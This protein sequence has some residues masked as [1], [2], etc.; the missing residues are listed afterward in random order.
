MREIGAIL[1]AGSSVA[2][3]WSF[4]GASAS[5]SSGPDANNLEAFALSALSQDPAVAP[6]LKVWTSG[7]RRQ[8]LA[9]HLLDGAVL[10]ASIW[11]FVVSQF[12]SVLDSERADR[13][14]KA[15]DASKQL[16]Q[17]LFNISEVVQSDASMDEVLEIIHKDV[18]QLMYA[19]NF[20]VLT[21]D[22]D[23]DLVQLRY[24]VDEMDEA[25]KVA[26]RVPY[27]ATQ[28]TQSL[29]VRMMI[30]GKPLLGPSDDLCVSLG[31]STHPA[32]GSPS[33]AWLG[34]PMMS[35][36]VVRGAIVVQSY[37]EEAEYSEESLRILEFVAQHLQMALDQRREIDAL[38][39]RVYERTHQLRNANM[40][41][42]NEISERQR[43]EALQRTLFRI[44]ELSTAPISG[45]R[46]FSE[47]HEIISK[48]VDCQNFFIALLDESHEYL[49]LAY[50]IDL[51]GAAPR[52][53][54]RL[55]SITD[56]V[57]SHGRP[58]LLDRPAIQKMI[59]EG[60]V[61][62]AGEIP[63]SWLGVPLRKENS[64]IGAM[65]VQSYNEHVVYDERDLELFVFAA[66]QVGGALSRRTAV[67]ELE[68]RVTRRTQELAR[69]NRAL[70]AEIAERIRVEDRL[71]HQAQHDVLTGL[72]N[73]RQLL[74]RL[75][76]DMRNARSD[77]TVPSFAV[78][79]LDM[80]Q[81]KLVNDS[82]GHAAGDEMLVDVARRLQEHVR[83][84]DLVARLGG[85]EFA[86]LTEH[87]EDPMVIESMAARILAAF[88]R[89]LRIHDRELF[90]SASIGIAYWREGYF[91]GEELLRDADAAMYR[92]KAL[93]RGKFMVFDEE[94]RAESVRLLDLEAD[95]RRAINNES[96]EVVYQ[97]VVAFSGGEV[98]GYEALVRWIDADGSY[99]LPDDFIGMGE[100]S[101]LIQAVDWLVYRKVARRL[102]A[103]GT[104]YISINVSPQHFQSGDFVERLIEMLS[105]AGAD[106]NRLRIEITEN[107]LMEDD[108]LAMEVLVKL[109][110]HG[111]KT[112]LDDFGTGYS[113]LS[114]LRRFPLYGIKVDRSF[115]SG[116]HG[117]S[118]GSSEALVNA[119]IAMSHALNLECVAEGVETEY[120]AQHLAAAGCGFAQGFLYGRPAAL[121][122]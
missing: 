61:E 82:M 64:V 34:V 98:V 40:I 29:A 91:N 6:H 21:W 22:R 36:G 81:F 43:G 92:A 57:V 99:V 71:H 106:V 104:T 35:G 5:C 122:N 19:R 12:E 46:F 24:F 8:A 4:G 30:G 60:R 42:Q 2:G 119:I 103:P 15:L 17:A 111:V 20:M 108:G 58:T 32:Y 9:L 116:M 118:D 72:A 49:E 1:P 86:I 74:D 52:R 33:R 110:R 95:L 77:G 28:M 11:N 23:T 3:A 88:E 96:F 94:M 59:E 105:D 41:L 75:S 117:D 80:D 70:L 45:E 85:D 101:G 121:S 112:L 51:Q 65:V 50:R 31:I 47:V 120:Q 90:P 13:Q 10:E 54:H 109:R 73:R 39:A 63:Y 44:S 27:P 66:Q 78:L 89:P 97:P 68:N 100:D 56:Y 87:F 25:S 55:N 48:L 93:G 79:Y 69:S 26:S 113:A 76:R 7:R 53:R 115:I 18:A 16:Q 107:A 67:V 102:A 83:P 38:E 62:A 37:E 114:Y 14:V 84:D